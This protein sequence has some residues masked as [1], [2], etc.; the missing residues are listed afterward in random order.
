M[1]DP[2]RP[3]LIAPSL[4][5]IAARAGAAIAPQASRRR[6]APGA[7]HAVIEGKADPVVIEG[8]T[9]PVVIEG[10][11]D[12]VVIEGRPEPNPSAAARA[13]AYRQAAREVPPRRSPAPEAGA[14]GDFRL[15]RNPVDLTDG[16]MVE[17]FLPDILGRALARSWVDA[18]FR[19]RLTADPKALLQDHDVNL[20]ATIR[21]ETQMG[22]NGR[23]MIVVHER[24]PDGG[25]RRLCYLQ[26]VMLAGK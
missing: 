1:T 7:D 12:P 21:I 15:V 5:R 6:T 2:L 19:A 4:R 24:Q 26:L 17:E 18:S 25:M 22:A 14:G 10:T 16:R 8:T 9:D 23:P 3:T 20:P 13:E 11:A